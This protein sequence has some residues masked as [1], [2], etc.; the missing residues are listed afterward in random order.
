MAPISFNEGGLFAR[1]NWSSPEH[2]TPNPTQRVT[3]IVAGCYILVI[4]ILVRPLPSQ[5]TPTVGLHEM[6][7]ALAGV[8]TCAR[9]ESIQLDPNEGGCTRMRGGIQLITLPAGYLGS[10]AFGAALIACGFDI[11]ASKV[12]CLVLAPLL[13]ITL[14]WARR[15]WVAYATFLFTGILIAVAWVVYHSVGLRFLVLFIGVMSCLY[16]IWD[17]IDDTLKRKIAASDASQFAKVVHFGNSYVWGTFW[18][19]ISILFFGAGL[20]LGIAAFKTSWDDQMAAADRFLGG[21]PW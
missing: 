11:N 16:C 14:W 1:A 2:W 20:L 3:L 15:S 19:L 6:S 18:L 7:H 9:I 21:S 10:S 4:G 5:L 13:L 12:A 8:L 17:I